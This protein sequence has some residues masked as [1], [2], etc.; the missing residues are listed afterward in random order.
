MKGLTF[1]SH[2]INKNMKKIL[3]AFLMLAVFTASAQQPG[4]PPS[5]EEK[6][7]EPKKCL[8]RN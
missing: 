7:K 3:S 1:N 5:I 2:L 6:L 4:A 8:G